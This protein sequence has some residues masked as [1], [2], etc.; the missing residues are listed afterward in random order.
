MG[1]LT[2]SKE[3]RLTKTILRKLI[4]RISIGLSAVEQ[5]KLKDTL[6]SL[7]VNTDG[8]SLPEGMELVDLLFDNASVEQVAERSKRK[9]VLKKRR[10]PRMPTARISPGYQMERPAEPQSSRA[11][12][13]SARPLPVAA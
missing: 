2:K 7:T 6:L 13:G 8:T 10:S 9:A 3:A 1:L 5:Q 11:S 4:V 12:W